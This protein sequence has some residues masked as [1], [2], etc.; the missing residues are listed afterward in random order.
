[1]FY[2]TS[3][4]YAITRDRV[5]PANAHW[6]DPVALFRNKLPLDSK[7]MKALPE[8]EKQIPI[9]VMLDSGVVIPANSKIVWPYLCNRR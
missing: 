6:M 4:K 5:I 2:S 8:A 1:V 7:A 3:D 9:S